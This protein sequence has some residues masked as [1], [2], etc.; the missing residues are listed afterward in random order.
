MCSRSWS[1]RRELWT[2]S[3]KQQRWEESERTLLQGRWQPTILS[4]SHLH[5]GTLRAWAHVSVCPHPHL[6]LSPLLQALQHI[7]GG[8]CPDA[9]HLVPLRVLSGQGLVA[10]CVAHNGAVAASSGRGHPT[11]LEAGGA[12][13]DQMY[14]LRG[15]R[16]GC[17]GGGGQNH[18]KEGYRSSKK[19]LKLKQTNTITK[20][21]QT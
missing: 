1:R 12:Q 14:L 9:H 2:S 11:H 20:H 8:I 17:K 18:T 6:I 21:R 19:K 5:G 16:W 4:G 10:D 3:P 7:A 15:C 13:A